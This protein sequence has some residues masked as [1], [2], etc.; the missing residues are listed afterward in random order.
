VPPRGL[1][2]DTRR[3]CQHPRKPTIQEP[4]NDFVGIA[5]HITSPPTLSPIPASA[6]FHAR[7]HP[8]PRFRAK[9]C[10]TFKNR[11][12]G[13]RAFHCFSP[14]GRRWDEVAPAVRYGI[15]VTPS[16]RP[17]QP[18]SDLSDF[19]HV[20]WRSRAGPTSRGARSEA[21]CPPPIKATQ[22]ATCFRRDDTTR[23]LQIVAE[24]KE[25]AFVL[26]SRGTNRGRT[27]RR[28]P[29]VNKLC[30]PRDRIIFSP[31]PS[32]DFPHPS[33]RIRPR[34]RSDARS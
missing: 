22:A 34:S 5:L 8:A 3:T 27:I 13:L 11:L 24:I 2:K 16:P 17:L 9:G 23:G 1:N 30:M 10:N 12:Q 15:I 20:S 26:R 6:H 14:W 7:G 25:P 21:P 19:G 18:K 29:L 4:R 32:R 33:R 28:G 31:I